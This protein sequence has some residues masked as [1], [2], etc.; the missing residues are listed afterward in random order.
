MRHYLAVLLLALSGTM[1][2]SQKIDWKKMK[3]LDPD[4]ILL[5][6][7]RQ[8]TK[9]LLLGTFHF[10]YPNLDAHKTDSSKFINVL[11]KSRQEELQQLADVIKNFKPTRVYIESQSPEWIDS[12]YNEYLQDRYKLGRNEIYQVAFRVAKQM[13]LPKIYSVDAWNFASE[14]YKKI[15]MIDSMWNNNDPVDSLRDKYWKTK[16]NQFYSAGDSI[17]TTLTMLENFLLMAEPTTL[18]RMHGAYL[19]GGFNTKNN[20]GPDILSMWW[21]SRNLRIFNNILSTRPGPED[22]IMILFG[23]GHMPILKDCFESCP[24]FEVVELKSLLK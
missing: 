16:F 22:R 21:Y 10:G 17:E 12:L 20:D 11:S 8:P 3:S 9:A 15:P 23:N 14:F 7:E 1:A 19:T 6:G 2:F 4:K 24:E 5:A 18:R 13:K